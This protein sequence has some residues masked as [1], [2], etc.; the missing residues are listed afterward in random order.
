MTGTTA[1][2]QARHEGDGAASSPVGPS[3]VPRGAT[4]RTVPDPAGPADPDLAA[5]V[6]PSRRRRWPT[7]RQAVVGGVVA[8]ALVG[9]AATQD[10]ALRA[11][12][13]A[14]EARVDAAHAAGR[15]AQFEDQAVT[16]ELVRTRTEANAAGA[17]EAR[18]AQRE[19]LVELQ[20]A[21]DSLEEAVATARRDADEVEAE[22]DQL[23]DQVQQ[24][25]TDLPQLERCL[26]EVRPLLDTA[27]LA[28]FNPGLVVPPV[29]PVCRALLAAVDGA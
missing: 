10:A 7:W 18:R 16:G 13:E 26:A 2:V 12:R 19:R 5:T 4:R 27:F 20:L 29:S 17:A 1:E 28:A 6:G 23:D 24:Q 14:A 3:G 8:G 22:R 25:A 15:R 11:R 9:A 21:E